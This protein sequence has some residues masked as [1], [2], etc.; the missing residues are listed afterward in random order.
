V[1]DKPITPEAAHLLTSLGSV[2]R[3]V[4]T[5]IR[6][7]ATGAMAP[8]RQRAFAGL[9][10]ELADLLADH[11]GAAEDHTAPTVLADRVGTTGRQLVAVSTRLRTHTT[12]SDQLR[13]VAGLLVALAEAL[14][15]YAGKMPPPTT[16]QPAPDAGGRHALKPPRGTDPT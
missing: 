1:S 8:D 6:E 14:Q 7:L 9:L 3:A 16:D 12:S 13:E 10:M 15:L 11:A 2:N 4:P 5:V